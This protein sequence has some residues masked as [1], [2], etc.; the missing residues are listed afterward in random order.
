M[1]TFLTI[2]FSFAFFFIFV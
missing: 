2:F 1:H